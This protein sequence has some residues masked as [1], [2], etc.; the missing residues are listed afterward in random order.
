MPRC[1]QRS[2]LVYHF[3]Q[4]LVRLM[5]IYFHQPDRLPTLFRFLQTLL[6]FSEALN[7]D[8]VMKVCE[9]F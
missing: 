5:E 3:L 4:C 9:S 8:T 7:Y 1:D 6:M 2:L